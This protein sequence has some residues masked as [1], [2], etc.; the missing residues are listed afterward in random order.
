[1]DI[2]VI[3]KRYANSGLLVAN[4]RYGSN[5]MSS[6]MFDNRE[7]CPACGHFHGDKEYPVRNEG[8][9]FY[10]LCPD[11]GAKIYLVWV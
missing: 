5:G 1:M 2:D 10:M 6:A 4:F 8:C 9:Y 3:R 7:L 11:N